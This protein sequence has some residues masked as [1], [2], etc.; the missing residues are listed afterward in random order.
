MLRKLNERT[1]PV[2]YTDK[3]YTEIPTLLPEF[4]Q[5]AYFGGLAVGAI[6]GRL[7]PIAGSA[8]ANKLYVMTIG[9]LNEYRQRG[10]GRKLLDLLLVNASAKPDVKVVYLHV[11]TSNA[12][13]LAFYSAAGFETLGRLENYYTKIAPSDCFVLA[14]VL[15]ASSGATAADYLGDL[16]CAP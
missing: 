13:A 8:D 15:D 2:R 6:C 9:V 14:K 12:A 5:F 4:A 7:E 16:G 3:F 11:Q 1:F 10:V